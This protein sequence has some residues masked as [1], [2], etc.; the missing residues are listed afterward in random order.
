MGNSIFLEPTSTFQNVAE[1][2]PKLFLKAV[3]RNLLT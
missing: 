1:A 2:R 3:A